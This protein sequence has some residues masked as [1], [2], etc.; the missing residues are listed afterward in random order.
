M[1]S[2]QFNIE[3]ELSKNLKSHI[4]HIQFCCYRF[5]KD[6]DEISL[7][8]SEVI[9][10]IWTKRHLFSGNHN[11][12]KAWV[13]TITRNSFISKYNK[14]KENP[15]CDISEMY[16]QP[17]VSFD[18]ASDIDNKKQIKDILYTI[19]QKFTKVK[20]DLFKANVIECKKYE[21]CAEEFDLPMGTVKNIIHTIRTYVSDPAN[22]ISEVVKK[23]IGVNRG[24]IIPKTKI[25]SMLI[26]LEKRYTLRV[27]DLRAL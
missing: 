13:F 27:Q 25:I 6:P 7:L 15:T 18:S 21:E 17:S 14:K 22:I 10:K 9:E 4:G 5:L 3:L 20:A 24:M 1:H 16:D 23:R 12:F 19:E 2:K 8:K 26:K 11:E